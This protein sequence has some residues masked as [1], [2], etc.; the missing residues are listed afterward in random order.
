MI[1]GSGYI[2]CWLPF[3]LPGVVVVVVF[4][5]T[6]W[7]W[8]TFGIPQC[9][10]SVVL[11]AGPQQQFLME[12]LWNHSCYKMLQLHT[13]FP[14]LCFK[15]TVSGQSFTEMSTATFHRHYSRVMT[16]LKMQWVPKAFSWPLSD[17]TGGEVKYFQW[18]PCRDCLRNWEMGQLW[19]I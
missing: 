13:S 11:Q 18:N 3:L 1:Y 16:S 10:P 17:F 15:H 4:I 19:T 5:Y 12:F 7:M 6:E 14:W 9:V 2:Q 8:F